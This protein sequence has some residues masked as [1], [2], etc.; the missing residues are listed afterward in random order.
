MPDE[1]QAYPS[2]LGQYI[3]AVVSPGDAFRGIK[4]K[5]RWFV[6]FLITLAVSLAT[7][8]LLM[9]YSVAAQREIIDEILA[10]NRDVMPAEQVARLEEFRDQ[11]GTGFMGEVLPYLAVPVSLFLYLL[12]ASAGLN[13][14]VGLTGEKLGFRNAV[15]IVSLASVAMV[16]GTVVMLVLVLVKGDVYVG[17][18]L[19]LLFPRMPA[20]WYTRVLKG[21]ASQIDVFSAWS[22]YLL[23]VGV[24]EVTGLAVKRSFR[25]V[26]I[27]WL[28]W[29]LVMT[30]LSYF[31]FAM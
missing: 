10:E 15:S 3:D 29:A 14:G 1:E 18:N 5:P 17:T 30:A 13:V 16:A 19:G 7:L 25:V 12:V 22:V 11:A 8:P 6:F 21:F 9:P 26:I 2:P 31:G 4:S 23:T 27:L 20:E 28:L 24:R